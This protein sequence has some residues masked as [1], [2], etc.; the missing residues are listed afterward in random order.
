MR[1]QVRVR[2]KEARGKK[3]HEKQQQQQYSMS[4]KRK[5]KLFCPVCTKFVN[6]KK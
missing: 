4:G 6:D 3:I 1:A 5:T 2:V